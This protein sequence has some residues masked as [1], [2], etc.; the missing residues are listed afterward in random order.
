MIFFETILQGP[1]K[2]GVILPPIEHTRPLA[3]STD[4]HLQISK[5]QIGL[6]DKMDKPL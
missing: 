3:P 2:G 5:E 1:F 4:E 6:L